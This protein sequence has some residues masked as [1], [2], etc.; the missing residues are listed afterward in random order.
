[1][2]L[3]ESAVEHDQ[4]VRLVDLT[5]GEPLANQRYRAMMEDGQILEGQTNAEGMTQI[6][7]SAIPF[8]H[9]TIEALYD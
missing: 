4:Q 8:G 2:R 5:T 7:K 3:P 9:F 6:L 1:M